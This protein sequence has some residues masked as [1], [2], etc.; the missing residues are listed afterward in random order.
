MA[1]DNEH[2]VVVAAKNAATAPRCAPLSNIMRVIAADSP[3]WFSYM[4]RRVGES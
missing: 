3:N 4:R 2:Y 1:D